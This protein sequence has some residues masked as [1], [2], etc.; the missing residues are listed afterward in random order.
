MTESANQLDW[1]RVAD[2]DELPEGRV[3]TVTAGTHSMALTHIDGAYT[4]MDNRSQHSP[5]SPRS[6]DPSPSGPPWCGQRLS[7][8]VYSPSMCVRAIE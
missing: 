7:I 6:I 8:A 4:A 1:Y 2:L 3:K 5:P